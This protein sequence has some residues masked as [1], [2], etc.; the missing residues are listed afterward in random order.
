MTDLGAIWAAADPEIRAAIIGAVATCATGA[1][2]FGAVIAQIGAQGR[3]NRR[4]VAESERRR[5]KTELYEQTVAVCATLQDANITFSNAMRLLGQSILYAAQVKAEG[6]GI[7]LNVARMQ[8]IMDSHSAMSNAATDFIF[9][10][11]R[12]QIIDPRLLV[13]RTAISVALYEIDQLYNKQFVPIAIPLL[14]ADLPNGQVIFN[15]PDVSAAQAFHQL[16]TNIANETGAIT[17]CIEDFLIEM[18]N[19]LL[20]D[21][22]KNRAKHR[23]P[24]DPAARVIRLDQADELEREFLTNT[25]WGKHVAHWEQRARLAFPEATKPASGGD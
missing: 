21:L 23:V 24:I 15:P 5:L 6:G 25:P 22:F 7:P 19:L 1:L 12:R 11:E 16:T 14:P 20:G 13:F 4:N 17:T 10:I 3:A 18:Q 8:T 2:G 9:L